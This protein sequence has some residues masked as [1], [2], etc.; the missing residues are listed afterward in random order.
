MPERPLFQLS[1]EFSAPTA[2]A[3]L[4]HAASETWPIHTVGLQKRNRQGAEPHEAALI[5]LQEL[6]LWRRFKRRSQCSSCT[7][8]PA[9][10]PTTTLNCLV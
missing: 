8:F 10:K 3:Q 4:A 7:T 6:H 1:R 2:A 9:S 5:T